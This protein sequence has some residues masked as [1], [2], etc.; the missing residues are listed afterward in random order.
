MRCSAFVENENADGTKTSILIDIGPEFRI[1]AIREHIKAI[2]AVLLTHSHSDHLHGLDD[3]RIFSH[4][5]SSGH[6]TN[7]KMGLETKGPGIAIYSNAQSLRDVRYRFAYVFRETQLGG[8]KPKLRLVD[9]RIFR[10]RQPQEFGD[11]HVTPIQMKHGKIDTTGWLLSVGQGENASG[12]HG[13]VNRSGVTAGKEVENLYGV[14]DGRENENLNGVR[15][16]VKNT[17]GVTGEVKVENKNRVCGGNFVE[18]GSGVRG[19]RENENLYGVR[20]EVGV[21]N[22]SGVTA[23]VKVE[24]AGGVTVG[25]KVE[26]ASDVTGGRENEN[27]SGVTAGVEVESANRV[28]GVRSFAYLTDCSYISD[29]SIEKIVKNG[30]VIEHCVIDG[31]RETPHSTHFSFLQAM[32]VAEKIKPVH[33]WFTHICH[34]KKHTEIS[35]YIK[36]HLQEFPNL[37]KIVKNGGSVEPAFD[38]QVI[39]V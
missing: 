31:L 26:N 38:R 17:S 20:D 23:G 4:T 39:W 10:K 5:I 24:N 9:E 36:Q 32:A 34:L 12:I 22:F 29:E 19:G 7:P 14:T 6:I 28:R 15:G 1:Q 35:E 27:F 3:I 16:A 30:G 25:V 8:G 11:I 13:V 33:T 18:N 21:K 37:S 2:D